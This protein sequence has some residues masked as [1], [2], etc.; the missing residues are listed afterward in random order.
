MGLSADGTIV[1]I[2]EIHTPDSSRYWYRES[3]ERAMSQGRDPEALDKEFVRRW[4]VEQG[5]RGEGSP[6][7]LPDDV[8][9]EASRRYIEAYETVTGLPF[10]PDT[11]EPIARIRRNLGNFFHEKV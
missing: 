10:E 4:L 6:P 2:D 5:W 1:V 11:E 3:Y 8:R 7:T 9:V